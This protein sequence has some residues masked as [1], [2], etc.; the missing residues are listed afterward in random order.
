M[1]RLSKGVL[2]YGPLMVEPRL[3]GGYC[4]WRAWFGW[5]RAAASP[6][7]RGS[8]SDE[9]VKDLLDRCDRRDEWS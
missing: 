7:G 2:R 9:A 1:N 4:E 5:R 6:V 8:T 3:D